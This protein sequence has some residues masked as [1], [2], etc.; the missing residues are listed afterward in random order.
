MPTSRITTAISHNPDA[1]QAVAEIQQQ[2][3]SQLSALMCFCSSRYDL[4]RLGAA[5]HAAFSCPI[6]GC[7]TAGEIHHA[8]GYVEG[9]LVAMGFGPG[10]VCLDPV[11]IQPLAND[12]QGA[13]AS[14]VHRRILESAD[15]DFA[16][17]LCDGLSGCEEY[18]IAAVQHSL[19]RVPVIGGS[20]GDD[21]RFAQTHVYYQG[22]F[23]SNAAVLGL[24]R[25]SLQPETLQTQH[26]RPSPRK[27]VITEAEV[28]Q[29]LVRE[30]DG[31]PAA[32]AYA[33]AIGCQAHELDTAAFAA[34]PLMLR[35]GGRWFVRSVQQRHDDDSLTFYCA[36]DQGLV[37][38]LGEAED[39]SGKVQAD[40]N[41]LQQ[42]PGSIAGIIA[43]DCILRRIDAMSH[44][45]LGRLGATLSDYPIV[46]MSSYG[47]QCHGIHVNHTM[48]GLVLRGAI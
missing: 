29:R 11:L 7:T 33:A 16:L 48:T 10:A 27:L 46:G 30:I 40:L 39:L 12:A 36:I 21:G 23:H 43:F 28:D 41:A 32:R 42:K 8:A 18:L 1:D 14:Q 44:G 5:L 13:L 20:A 19:G 4:T 26:F 2:L 24:C 22:H 17:L 45:Q 31:I 25:S 37:L 34:H 47:E 15:P 9:S 6:L 38:T 3:G 35:L